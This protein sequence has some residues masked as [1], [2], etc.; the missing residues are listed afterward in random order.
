M[1]ASKEIVD[2]VHVLLKEYAQAYANKDLEGMM[3]LFVQEPDLV[4]I[5][6]G[7]DE[8]VRGPEELKNGLKRDMDQAEDIKVDYEDVTVS[9]SGKVVWVSA[10]MAMY[11]LLGG[12]EITMF[13]R[14][15]L[16][17]E[18]REKLWLISHLHFS[19]P[20][21]QEEGKSYPL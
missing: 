9:S 11:V 20:D 15:S 12:N 3:G 17:L 21:E 16:V 19:V 4:A 13:G 14:L 7:R 18:E 10:R 1:E 8:W 6:A 5:G 2:S